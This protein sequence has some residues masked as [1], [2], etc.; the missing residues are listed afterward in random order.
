MI[1][2]DLD[3]TLWNTVGATEKAAR[4]IVSLNNEIK[5]FD[6]SAV[7]NGKRLFLVANDSFKKDGYNNFFIN[8]NKYNESAQRFYEKMGGKV[9]VVDE[10]CLDKSEAQIHYHYDVV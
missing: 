10:D 7:K 1:I 9:V 6:I 3:G 2:F 8:C 5:D 4:E